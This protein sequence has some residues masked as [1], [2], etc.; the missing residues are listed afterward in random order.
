MFVSVHSLTK[1]LYDSEAIS[2]TCP[3][4]TG[5]ITILDHHRPLITELKKGMI[6]IV[7]LNKK[8]E[9]IPIRS[10]FLEVQEESRVKFIID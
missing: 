4:T 8:E 3:T 5:E 7:D 9:Y 1:T 10:G 2:V 6:K